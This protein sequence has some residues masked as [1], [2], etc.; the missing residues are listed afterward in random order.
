MCA[1]AVAAITL[2]API[3]NGVNPASGAQGQTLSVM[4]AGSNFQNGAACSFGSGIAVNSCT[5]NSPAQITSTMT[6][7]GS[8]ATGP[9]GIQ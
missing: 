1:F 8:A 6:I 4:I 3:V 9:R 7:V 5:V 2:P